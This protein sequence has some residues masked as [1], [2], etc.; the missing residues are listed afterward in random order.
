MDKILFTIFPLDRP[1][2]FTSC[3]QAATVQIDLVVRKFCFAFD[4]TTFRINAN[5][6]AAIDIEHQA[7]QISLN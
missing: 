7:F 3:P 6:D 5:R 1:L 4:K 2:I